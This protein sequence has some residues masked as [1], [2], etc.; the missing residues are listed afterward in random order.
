M[1]VGRERERERET[2]TERDRERE[3]QRERQFNTAGS[4][5]FHLLTYLHAIQLAQLLQCYGFV[6]HVAQATHKD[7]HTL[8]L[9]LTRKDT[10][11]CKVHVGG[12]ISDHAPAFFRLRAAV[13]APRMQQVTRIAWRRLS[14]DA[15]AS[16]LSASE[17]R[18]DLNSLE[19]LTAD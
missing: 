3:R 14:T 2:E 7:G 13:V 5:E 12:L 9:V 17:L 6:L 11:V 16:D 15:F 18:V 1:K 10:T 19:N 4:S 8:D